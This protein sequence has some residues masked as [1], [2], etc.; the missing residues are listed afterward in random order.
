[1][2]SPTTPT[3]GKLGALYVLRPNG[4]SGSGLN[5]LT[6]GTGSTA[7]DLTYYEVVIDGVGTGTLGVDTFKWRVN[8]GA[9]TETV[10]ITGAE[11]TLA[12]GQKLTFGAID[13]HTV[14]DKWV[15]GNLKDEAT[16]ESG[17]TAQI[18]DASARLLNPNAPPIWT[19]SGGKTV[20]QVNFT[21]GTAI[22]NGNVGNVTVTGNNGFIPTSALQKVGYLVD[23][24]LNLTLD[25][26]DCS[27]MGQ[28]WKEALPGQAGGSGSA[29]GYFI[30][31][32]TL[33]NNL[34]EAIA[35]GEKYFLLQLFTND[36]DQDQTGDHINA[37]VTFTS[38]NVGATIGAVVK[39][40]VNFQV[41]GAVSFTADA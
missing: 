6:W 37:W 33:L 25:M 32:Q 1:M 39:E 21:N 17:E 31:T 14:G 13:G 23:W 30:A 41:V 16:S 4:F 12:D 28:Q 3:H 36:P 22:F 10:D 27:R 11:Q 18:T 38:F 24:N 15:I 8:G 26:A 40:Q 29:S 2:G 35:Q 9:W 34:Q 20:E 5:D 19:D 7:L